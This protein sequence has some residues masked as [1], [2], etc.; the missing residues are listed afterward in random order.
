M[1][2]VILR[3]QTFL[4]KCESKAYSLPQKNVT[5]L[6]RCELKF[7]KINESSQPIS[8]CFLSYLCALHLAVGR[9]SELQT[10]SAV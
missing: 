9:L 3:R 4:F 10:L 6:F 1:Y 8:N 2:F 5:R 7:K